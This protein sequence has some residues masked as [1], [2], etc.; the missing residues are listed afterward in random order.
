MA[1]V[2]LE[3]HGY[4]YSVY[5]WIARLALH[6]KGVGYQWVEVDPFAE[7]V[8]PEYLALHP[9]KR[10]P[11]LVHDDFV[12]FETSAITRYVDEGFDGP[13]LQPLKAADRARVS[14]VLSIVDSYAY[15]PL[16]RQV[17]SHGV[18]RPRLGRPAHRSEY[19]RGLEATPRVL[20]ALDELA[21]GG[22]FL[23][24]DAFSL[25]DIHL[26][27]ML[28]YLT[29]DPGGASL[30]DA[31]SRLRRW[32]SKTAQRKSVAETRPALP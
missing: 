11:T 23:V 16:V 6:E 21:G 2:T 27:P 31:H 7:N 26:A 15:W 17:F 30:L 12:V 24:S 22:D 28:D 32:W 18:F 9:F 13:K 4:R 5:S 29:A 14:Q 8:P 25:A 10:V 19:Q 20:R 3:L 1:C